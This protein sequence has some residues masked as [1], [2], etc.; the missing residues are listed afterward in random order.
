MNRIK[1]EIEKICNEYGTSLKPELEKLCDLAG[2]LA[3]KDYQNQLN[4]VT[5]PL[6]YLKGEI[7]E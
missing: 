3:I 1:K 6:N 4:T 7:S 5:R 2:V